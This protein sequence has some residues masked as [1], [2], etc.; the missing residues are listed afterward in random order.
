MGS[1]PTQ[2]HTEMQGM[3]WIK[4]WSFLY[5][6]FQLW[7]VSPSGCPFYLLAL[8]ISFQGQTQKLWVTGMLL[9]NKPQECTLVTGGVHLEPSLLAFSKEIYVITNRQ[10]IKIS[11]CENKDWRRHNPG[12]SWCLRDREEEARVHPGALLPFLHWERKISY[13]WSGDVLQFVISSFYPPAI[14]FNMT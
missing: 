13:T 9:W 8:A 5:F 10:C 12:N 2:Y 3:A 14:L 4:N 6:S 11:R 7:L 1:L